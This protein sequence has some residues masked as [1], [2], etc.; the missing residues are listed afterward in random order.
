MSFPYK[1]PI[2][3]S[4]LNGSESVSREKTFGT[5]FSVLSVGGYMEVN[6]LNDLTYTVPPLTTGPIN[7]SGNTIPVTFYKSTGAP[8]SFD[9]L[10]LNSDNISSGRKKI[11]ML[12]YVREEDQVYQFN[13]NNYE[14]LWNAATGATGV[15][16]SSVI[17]SDFGTTVKGNTPQGLSFISGWTT[18]TIDGVS[19]ETQSTAVWKKYYGNNLSITGGTYSSGTLS[20]TNITGGTVNI[21]G[22]SSGGGGGDSITGGTID[23]STGTLSLNSTGGTVTITGFTDTFV[24]GGTYS[25]GTATFTNNTGGTFN[26]TGFYTGNTDNDRY[27][28][29]FTYNNNTFT[30]ADN[31]GNTLTATFNDV[32]G[33]TVNGNLI[34]TGDTNL[35]SLTANTIS[36]T[37]YQNLPIQYGSFG[38]VIDGSGSVITT[39]DKGYLSLPYSGI[40]TGWR[41]IS[42]Q[43]GDVSIDVWKTDYSNFPPT[44]GDTI[45]GG[46]YPTLTSQQINE[47]YVLTGWSTNFLS[48]D[49]ISF[50]VI[51]SAAVTR[52]NLTINVIKT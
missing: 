41:I 14:T 50:N 8:F 4:Q 6:S 2:S 33:L 30:L 48:G 47:D 3:P 42:D 45:T 17:I 34:V 49:I 25:S 38:I 5:N 40:I 31:S 23:Y 12:V 37:T 46:N 43:V 18:N 52:I 10:T 51:S 44:S 22:F 20:L 13:I 39:G 32:T 27:T 19:G 26:V 1:N 11:G 35:D 21:T 36:A 7:N 24:T 16:G 9:T 29:G 15:G 28:T